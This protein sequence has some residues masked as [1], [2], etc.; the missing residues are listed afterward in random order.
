MWQS[1]TE[2]AH[3]HRRGGN[4]MLTGTIT[5]LRLG[6][7]VAALAALATA[8]SA[9]AV[10][11]LQ[12]GTPNL[13]N[14]T[15]TLSGN[16]ATAELLV[17]NTNGASASAFGLYGLL[18]A[19]SPTASAAAVRGHNSALNGN[20]YGVYGSQGGS[21]TGVYGFAPSGRG[22]W[23]NTTSG[24][25]VRAQSTSGI[26]VFGQHT[27]TTGTAP[28]VF[29]STNS[30]VADAYALVATVTPTSPG[31]NSEAVRGV[32][33]G[34][35]SN[36][37]GVYGQQNG[38]GTGV[39]GSS[40]SGRGV[41]GF[42][43]TWTGVY[44]H[45]GSQAGVLGE[46]GTGDGVWGQAHSNI[47]AGISG[48]NDAGGYGVWGGSSTYG[49]Y[50]TGLFGVRGD[51]TSGVA[52]YGT[53]VSG[54]GVFGMSS[55]GDAGEFN[56]HVEIT[57]GCTGCA[58]AALKIDHPLDPAH[59][60]LQHSSV[61]SSQQLNIYSGNATTDGKGFATV[62]VPRWFQALNR[63]FRYQL[64]VVGRA[65]WDAKAAVW[66]EIAHNRFT[67]RTDQPSVKVSWQVTG[68][69]HDPYANAHRIQVVVPKAKNDQGKYLH[70]ELYGKP[71]SA[72]IGYRKPPR[73]PRPARK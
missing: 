19:T 70:H 4:E 12:L 34:T 36:G 69:R 23:G 5:R 53:S 64:T 60:Y 49:V 18:T 35:G 63:S 57:G 21:G 44:G 6:L 2:F 67:I 54:T 39:Q 65:H 62:T 24:I 61:A 51:S 13:S 42:S 38:S 58:G 22:V 11:Y 26:G 55:T 3:E 71:K 43:N 45:S 29:A 28:G 47:R 48:H 15:T 72:A 59:K 50:G 37:I 30:T 46:S 9:Q 27:A 17:R 66:E 1:L 40:P 20:G 56:G 14:A 31:L 8:S 73:L 68:I 52:V 25:G 32:N 41:A 33:N 7:L 16:P 10:T